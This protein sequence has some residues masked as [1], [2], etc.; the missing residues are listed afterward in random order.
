VIK[1]VK[2]YL[3]NETPPIR[4]SKMKVLRSLARTVLKIVEKEGR[5]QLVEGSVEK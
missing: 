5:L 3:E 2:Y 4:I 1:I